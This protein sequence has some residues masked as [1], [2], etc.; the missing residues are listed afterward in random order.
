[1]SSIFQF[2]TT[3]HRSAL[4]CSLWSN[5]FAIK[6]ELH[7]RVVGNIGNILFRKYAWI[8]MCGPDTG[9]DGR[10]FLYSLSKTN[11]IYLRLSKV[12]RQYC[13]C[14][15]WN[16]ALVD[17]AGIGQTRQECGR[18]TLAPGLYISIYFSCMECSLLLDIFTLNLSNSV[19]ST[20]IDIGLNTHYTT[21]CNNLHS[22][23]AS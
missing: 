12:S 15:H 23:S 19:R 17:R 13:I 9:A 20:A 3:V 7:Y 14:I 16:V 5:V 2:R 6:I 21:A 18:L 22:L 10:T 4:P 11:S 1:M 8:K